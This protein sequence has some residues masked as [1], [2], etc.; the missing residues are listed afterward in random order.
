MDKRT[1]WYYLSNKRLLQ[2]V[3]SEEDTYLF[4]YSYGIPYS[5]PQKILSKQ[6]RLYWRKI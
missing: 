3:G 6:S 1:A 5:F 2:F 4:Q